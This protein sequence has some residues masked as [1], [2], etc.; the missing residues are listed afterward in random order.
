MSDP[1][2]RDLTS[3]RIPLVNAENNVQIKVISGEF[4]GVQGPV[5]EV[6]IKPYYLDVTIPKETEFTFTV[7]MDHTLF[8]YVYKGSALFGKEQKDIGIENLVVYNQ[9]EFMTV[10]TD[11]EE[12]KILLVAGKP[13]N[14]PIAWYGPMVMNT[15]DEIWQAINDYNEGNFIKH[16]PTFN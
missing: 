9:G 5:N 3:D 15:Q 6:S 7:P 14:E 16:K 2:Y 11:E 8:N 4:N 1:K 10:R 12:V 13:L